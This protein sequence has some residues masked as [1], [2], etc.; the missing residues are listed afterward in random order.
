MFPTACLI[1][2]P[3]EEGRGR[4]GIREYLSSF[5]GVKYVSKVLL[6]YTEHEIPTVKFYETEIQSLADSVNGSLWTV[7]DWAAA[8]AALSTEQAWPRKEQAL[9]SGN[10]Y[11]F[12]GELFRHPIMVLL[13][14]ETENAAPVG[15]AS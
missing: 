6:L 12:S 13:F 2:S 15:A 9:N 3:S 4:L 7:V 11:S 8:S 10:R 5:Y 1:G 14:F